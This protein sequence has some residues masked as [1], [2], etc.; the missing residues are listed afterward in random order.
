MSKWSAKY[1]VNHHFKWRTWS[2]RGQNSTAFWGGGAWS[3]ELELLLGSC[4]SAS[5]DTSTSSGSGYSSAA[6]TSF[7]RNVPLSHRKIREST[8][9][10]SGQSSYHCPEMSFQSFVSPNT[11]QKH[12]SRLLWTLHAPEV[13]Y[14]V[15]LS[16]M[17]F[18]LACSCSIHSKSTRC[19]FFFGIQTSG[20]PFASFDSDHPHI[21]QGFAIWII[22][23]AASCWVPWSSVWIAGIKHFTAEYSASAPCFSIKVSS[24]GSSG[25]PENSHIVWKH[26]SWREWNPG[27]AVTWSLNPILAFIAIH[28][29]TLFYFFYR[30]DSSTLPQ[31][32]KQYECWPLLDGF[33]L[34][35]KVSNNTRWIFHLFSGASIM[36]FR[37]SWVRFAFSTCNKLMSLKLVLYVILSMTL[38]NVSATLGIVTTIIGS[39]ADVSAGCPCGGIDWITNRRWS[40]EFCLRNGYHSRSSPIIPGK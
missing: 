8:L 13:A 25:T 7:G 12:S 2:G 11:N 34:K 27:V 23:C 15:Y 21:V 14:E 4:R 35:V 29:P 38:L 17:V 24:S 19:A 5:F 33:A 20:F 28:Q 1:F 16:T 26:L 18:N 31:L 9:V 3:K 40:T 39:K 22:R 30:W 32:H 36:R 37:S 10:S 6:F